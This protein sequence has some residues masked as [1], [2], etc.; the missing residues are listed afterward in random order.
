LQEALTHLPKPED[1]LVF[2]DGQQLFQSL[3][4]I[5]EFIRSHAKNDDKAARIAHLID[6]VL[7][8]TAVLNYIVTV[9]YTE[10]AQNHS[11]TLIKMADGYES[12]LLGRAL[13]QDV[14]FDN[15]QTWVPQDATAYS[16]GTGINLH[17]L[18]NGIIKF[19][20]EEIPESKTGL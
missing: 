15:W 16:L 17:E 13:S 1:Q 8:E 10:P 20:Q 12:K 7:D 19:V 18:Y 6:R 4:G 5:G 9:E 14:T 3:H 11:V 2:F